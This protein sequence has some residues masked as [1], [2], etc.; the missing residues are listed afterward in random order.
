[1]AFTPSSLKLFVALSLGFLFSFH[2]VWAAV[3]EPLLINEIAIDP[4]DPRILYAAARPQ[5]VLKSTDRGM[6]WRTIRTGLT[7]TSGYH[8]VIHPTNPNILYLGTFGGGVYKSEDGGEHWFEANQGLGNT[9][10]HAL[11]INPL[12]PDQLTVATSTGKLFKSENGA[13]SW[14]SFNEGLPL[15]EGEVISTL[16]LFPKEPGGFYLAQRGLFKR[17]FSSQRWTVGANSL[18]EQVI[19]ALAYDARHRIMYAG[20]MKQGLFKT[21]LSADPISSRSRLNWTPAGAPF[22]RQ[23]IRLITLDPTNPSV[24]YVVAIGG[25]LY[26][27]TDQGGSWHEINA[28]LPTKAVTG[29]AID[30]TNPRFLYAGLQ[31][32][33]GLFLS[34]DGGAT[35]SLPALEIEPVQQ[36]IAS[37]SNRPPSAPSGG[38]SVAPPSS[39]AKCNQCHGWT[40]ASLNQ[41]ATFWRVSPNRRDWRPTV[42]RMAPGARLIPQEEEEIIRFLTDYSRQRS[43]TP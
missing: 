39:F 26:K 14:V 10:I 19:T 24:I 20:T 22:Q 18:S 5:G 40:D 4:K 36:I 12:Q 7:N 27:S 38:P 32:S 25:G 11:I 17:P 23:W 31:Y 21:T 9:N 41:R 28:G 29:L 33:D 43:Q 8:L 37:L 16:L 15:F 2:P 6:T 35:W 42:R 1:M 30:P 3:Q 13:T 34:R